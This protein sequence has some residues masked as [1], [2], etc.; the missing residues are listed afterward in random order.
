VLDKTSMKT[1]NNRK[2]GTKQSML[3]FSFCFFLRPVMLFSFICI[4]SMP[5]VAHGKILY[6]YHDA[7]W[8]NYT[9]ASE[10][11]WRGVNVALQEVDYNL[12][13]YRIEVVKKN[14]SGNVL[15]SLNNAK[16]FLDDKNALAVISGLH[17][18]PLIK[19]REFINKNKVLTLVPWAAGGPVTRYPSAENWVFRLSV[20][21]TKAGE[22][23]VDYALD[24]KGCK[25]PHM[26]LADNP[27][28]DSNLYSMGKALT[29][30]GKDATAVTRFNWNLKRY[31]AIGKASNIIASGADCVLLVANVIEGIEI[32]KAF[33][34]LDVDKRPS[35]I[36]HWGITGGDFHRQVSTQER[37]AV[38]LTFIQTCFSFMDS[39][40]STMGQ[41]VLN[42]AMAQFP[43]IRSPS[44]VVSPAGFI[45]GYDITRLLLAALSN[46]TLSDN[47][48]MHRDEL[49]IALE[50]IHVPV[51][52][53]VKTYNK[54]Y[55]PYSAA[56]VDAHEAL[57]SPDY[58]MASYDVNGDIVL[59]R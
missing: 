17:S 22:I 19:N 34:S 46:I 24:Q 58:C 8:A 55:G 59:K 15:R 42:K 29:A 36:S 47:A 31:S 13:G 30:R 6:L 11:I 44:D 20:D 48:E 12:Q 1:I 10:S 49:R 41:E 16:A 57:S 14:H 18:Q 53:L 43:D 33:A 50:N 21:D 51:E 25:S 38:D 3:S 35:I 45:H 52:G 54:P 4:S 23:L 28:G 5:A 56:Q 39:P 7:D 27:W 37:K 26:L 9:A 40:L 32:T 2:Y